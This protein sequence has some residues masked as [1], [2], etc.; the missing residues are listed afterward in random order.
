MQI[1]RILAG[2]P[3]KPVIK[4]WPRRRWFEFSF[5]EPLTQRQ[6]FAPALCARFW[7]CH[8]ESFEYVENNLG[9][10]KSSV[11]FVVGANDIPRNVPGACRTEAFLVRVHVLVPEFPLLDVRAPNFQFFSGSSI[12]CRKR[13]RC[14]SFE[15]WRKNL[16]M[17]VSLPLRCPLQMHDGPILFVP[18]SLLVVYRTGQPFA[19]ENLWMHAG[20]QHL[21]VIGAVED[22][23]PPAFRQFTGGAP[24][25]I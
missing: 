18:D 5:R 2:R 15:R 1:I 16:M 9:H 4:A 11:L 14:S 13:F 17:W 10:N 24:Q 12:R 23:D 19:A 25:K 21:L 20:D 3:A 22:S 8:F 7:I 6:Q